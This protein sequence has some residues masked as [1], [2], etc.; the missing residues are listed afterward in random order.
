M[1][2]SLPGQSPIA[3]RIAGWIASVVEA[4]EFHK[5]S[6]RDPRSSGTRQ[7]QAAPNLRPEADRK[8]R[9]GRRV[10]L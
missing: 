4:P 3:P 5:H 6:P 1:P 9:R 2:G 10:T 8:N 7:K